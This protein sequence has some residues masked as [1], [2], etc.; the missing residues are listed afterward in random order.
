MLVTYCA[1]NGSGVTCA[2]RPNEP[3]FALMARTDHVDSRLLVGSLEQLEAI[4]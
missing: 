1:Y 2:W 3:G 4:P